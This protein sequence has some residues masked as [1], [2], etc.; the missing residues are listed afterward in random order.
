ME[1]EFIAALFITILF[2]IMRFVEIRYVDKDSPPLK[3][4]VRDVIKVFFASFIGVFVFSQFNHSLTDFINV[5]TNNP[6]V[7]IPSPVIFTDEPTF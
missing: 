2:G 6:T 1:K 7:S 5:L 4:F 3:F